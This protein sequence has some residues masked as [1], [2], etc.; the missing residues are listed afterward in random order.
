MP[1][2]HFERDFILEFRSAG[3]EGKEL[4]ELFGRQIP[5]VEIDTE[6]NRRFTIANTT[7][8]TNYVETKVTDAGTGKYLFH[9]HHYS[10]FRSTLER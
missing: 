8:K 5:K 2:A 10:V 9:G 7:V 4:A 3:G 1:N 6:T